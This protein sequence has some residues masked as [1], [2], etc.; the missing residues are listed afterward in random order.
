MLKAS[1]LYMVII[2]ALV[3]SLICS[4]LI[5]AAYF[6]RA[7]YQLHFQY[8]RL[9]SNC[10]SGMQILLNNT[11]SSYRE[12]QSLSL[13]GLPTDSTILQKYPWGIFDIGV[14]K[15]FSHRDTLWRVFSIA[16]QVDSSKWSSIYLIDE[17]RPLSLSGKTSIQ[18]D[19]R[20][21]KAGVKTAYLDNQSYS[22]DEQLVKG[23]IYDS[24]RQLPPLAGP[25]L[26]MIKHLFRQPADNS[27]RPGPSAGAT[28][29]FRLPTRVIRLEAQATLQN[30][31]FN[32]NLILYSDTTLTIDSTVSLENVIVVAKSIQVKSGFHGHCQLYAT[33]SLSVGGN[34]HFTYP[35]CL[36]LVRNTSGITDLPGKISL[37][38]H[39][40][41]EGLIFTYEKQSSK[42]PPV[43][44]LAKNAVVSGQIY[45]QGSLSLKE[46]VIIRG[47]VM[48]SRFLYQNSI[49]SYENYLVNTRIDMTALSRYYLSSN[50]SPSAGATQHILQ[51]L[52]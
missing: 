51:W 22:G 16:N 43:I 45:S 4:A 20:L 24:D 12:P 47:G 41:L 32:G 1:S 50:L 9:V 30:A 10:N 5:S 28:R 11:D 36:A 37:G 2:I 26:E 35:S 49:T 8:D 29:S 25:R 42:L 19:A 14:I 34:C 31:S 21:P 23:H 18:G 7:Q 17:D 40:S 6:Y 38:E 33:D 52:K 3:I 46:G 15:T 13:S 27:G 48:T 39:S 44:S